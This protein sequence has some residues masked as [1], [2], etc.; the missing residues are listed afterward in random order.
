MSRQNRKQCTT[1]SLAQ[2]DPIQASP[3][4]LPVSLPPSPAYSSLHAPANGCA[5]RNR[6]SRTPVRRTT[7]R[8]SDIT[9]HYLDDVGDAEEQQLE[10][11]RS[12]LYQQLQDE[13]DELI[14]AH[15]KQIEATMA[16][17]REEMNLLAQVMPQPFA[18]CCVSCV[19]WHK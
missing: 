5:N 18:C 19:R 2:K 9:Q 4:H 16:I 3:L 11:E 12:Q 7:S 17:V 15:R 8:D 10:R 13:E 1:P 6:R 14:T